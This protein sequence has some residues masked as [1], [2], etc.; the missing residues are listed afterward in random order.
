MQVHR[1]NLRHVGHQVAHYAVF[2]HLSEA[3]LHP[4]NAGMAD[5]S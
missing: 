4:W 1:T 5:Q 3:L 2:P